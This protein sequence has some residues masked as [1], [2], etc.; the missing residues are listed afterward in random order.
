MTTKRISLLAFEIPDV[1]FPYYQLRLP[2]TFW[3]AARSLAETAAGWGRYPGISHKSL[4]QLVTAALPDIL[5]D[6]SGAWRQPDSVWLYALDTPDPRL[7]A[8]QFRSWMMEEYAPRVGD[9]KVLR[10]MEGLDDSE[11]RWDEASAQ[12][13]LLSDHRYAAIPQYV[14]RNW[15]DEPLQLG[16]RLFYLYRN[17]SCSEGVELV[18]WPPEQVETYSPRGSE[19]RGAY[20]SAV[21]R[22][23]ARTLP[24]RQAPLVYFHMGLRRWMSRPMVGAGGEVYLKRNTGVYVAAPWR[25][26]DGRKQALSFIKV[27]VRR[28]GRCVT[29]PRG[30]SDLLS[31]HVDL[32]NPAELAAEPTLG[33]NGLSHAPGVSMAIAYDN[34]YSEHR[35]QAGV[36]RKDVAALYRYV[37]ERFGDILRPAGWTSQA[38]SVPS[39]HFWN[40]ARKE[41]GSAA[42]GEE[43]HSAVPMQ[44][45]EI[46]SPA[47]FTP[48][49]QPVKSLVVLWER[50]ET[51]DALVHELAHRLQVVPTETPHLY[52]GSHGEVHIFMEEIDL[53]LRAMLKVPSG[54][55]G[56]QRQ[57]AI[58]Q[59]IEDRARAIAAGPWSKLTR[60]RADLSGAIVE[61]MPA[62]KTTQDQDPKLAWRIGMS[63][64]G[65]VNQHIHAVGASPSLSDQMR[66]TN[67][68]SDLLRQLG[69]MPSPVIDERLDGLGPELWLLGFAVLRRT[70][71]TAAGQFKVSLPIVVR[72]NPLTGVVEATE[73]RLYRS[74]A[75][76]EPYPTILRRVISMGTE[77]GL[78]PEAT[79]EFVM[80]AVRDCLFTPIGEC[81]KPGVLLLAEAQ[82]ARSGLLCLQD[83]RLVT[84]HRLDALLTRHLSA[85]ERNRFS[86]VRVRTSEP[87]GE[88][89]TFRAGTDLLGQT[90]GL[91][92]WHSVTSEDFPVY[93]S[94]SSREA[95]AIRYLKNNDS[96]FGA[97]HQMAWNNRP[98]EIVVLDSAHEADRIA[99]LVH[100]L[101]RRW[102]YVD[103]DTTLP[104]PLQFAM[105]A[106]EY[107]LGAEDAGSVDAQEPDDLFFDD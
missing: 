13:L 46:A 30:L 45:P 43:R 54:L 14:A 10:A 99:Y 75:L 4:D 84:R 44:R 90:R 77:G 74:D 12:S 7:I 24:G 22:I 58:S 29:W 101:R 6:A 11:W 48:H 41:K 52:K 105:L 16:D 70:S 59:A 39:K 19:G 17:A 3:Q 36:G 82:N 2:G 83:S 76:W 33:L 85:E 26:L 78:T 89:P 62:S 102:P 61:I 55:Y 21:V 92:R 97:A 106:R 71:K 50:P 96:R 93:L 65:F 37:T 28:Q 20:A 35:I 47:F 27:P 25:W 100:R 51:R 57:R 31:N 34:R 23:T 66:V 73:P 103:M 87:R 56:P 81:A 68:V 95:S 15:P 63:R 91:F 53:S 38:A 60:E 42:P 18:S 72:I 94:T 88:V 107:A 9:D 40:F 64:A 79:E 104:C 49:T 98:V 5:V 80:D 86:L 8:A 1:A 67:A 69:R 32:P